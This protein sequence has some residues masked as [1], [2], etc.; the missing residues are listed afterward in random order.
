MSSF[1]GNS[2]V[3]AVT[4][5]ERFFCAEDARRRGDP[6]DSLVTDRPLLL[7]VLLWGVIAVA[8]IYFKL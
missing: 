4:A 5:T 6:T 1:P 7:S 8:V 2:D 3:A